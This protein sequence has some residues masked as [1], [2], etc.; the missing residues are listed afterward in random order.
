MQK[1]KPAPLFSQEPLLRRTSSKKIP[2]HM[3]KSL[4]L[5]SESLSL[6]KKKRT[7]ANV[8]SSFPE[9]IELTPRICKEI[10][11]ALQSDKKIQEL[12]LTL[13]FTFRSLDK[14]LLYLTRGL[15]GLK[16]LYRIN[17]KFGA[18]DLITDT[19]VYY[20][21]KALSSLNS[22][23]SLTLEF[24]DCIK[25]ASI[26]LYFISRSLKRMIFLTP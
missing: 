11:K 26:D 20:M 3:Q 22:L 14:D 23:K 15:K 4:H 9:G 21:M 19:G 24:W 8:W 6:Q 12:S 16:S 7:S 5:T 1:I 25:I 18:F 2:Y 13:K 10:G 17:V